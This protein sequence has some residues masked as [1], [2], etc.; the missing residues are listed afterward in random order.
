[1]SY[2]GTPTPA[3]AA[4][5]FNVDFIGAVWPA[6]AGG[7]KGWWE[8]TTVLASLQSRTINPATGRV[9]STAGLNLGRPGTGSGFPLPPEVAVVTSLRTALAGASYRGRMYLPAPRVASNNSTGRLDATAQ[10]D[11]VVAMAAGMSAVNASTTYG[12]T[13]V[14]IY[15]RLLNTTEVVVQVDV[16]NVFDAQRRRRNSLAESRATLSV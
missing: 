6:T 1:V 16:G 2:T 7:L 13:D 9:I 3:Q 5:Q 14:V 4:A 11:I 12:T 15:S 8:A 10:N